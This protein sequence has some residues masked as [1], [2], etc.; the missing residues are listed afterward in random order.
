MPPASHPICT[1]YIHL[2]CIL[3]TVLRSRSYIVYDA[4]PSVVQCVDPAADYRELNWV[5]QAATLV[6]PLQDSS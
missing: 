4:M 5:L 6:T 3:M 1:Y 2:H